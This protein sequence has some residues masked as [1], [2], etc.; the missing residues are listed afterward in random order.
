MSVPLRIEHATVAECKP[1]RP[2]RRRR[3]PRRARQLAGIGAICGLLS[4]L[5]LAGVGAVTLLGGLTSHGDLKL[6]DNGTTS[7]LQ[8]V[9]G[10]AH[11]AY[12]YVTVTGSVENTGNRGRSNVEAIVELI[13]S[14]N[15]TVQVDK[16]MVAFAAVPAGDSA[17]FRVMVQDDATATGYRLSFKHPNGRSIN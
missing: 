17:P 2:L 11:R 3:A 1:Q 5:G 15:R 13:D 6:V 10:T 16:S 8:A 9:A 7:G 14:Q 4:V 12:G